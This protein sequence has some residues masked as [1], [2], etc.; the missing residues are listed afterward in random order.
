VS[1]T[2]NGTA[3]AGSEV[4][5]TVSMDVLDRI[6][7]S[8]AIPMQVALKHDDNGG[9]AASKG[10]WDGVRGRVIPNLSTHSTASDFSEPGETYTATAPTPTLAT[11]AAS[12]RGGHAN[13]VGERVRVEGYSVEGTLL[14]YG[15]CVDRPGTQCGVALDRPLGSHDGKVGGVRYF[16]CGV[17]CGVMAPPH[18]VAFVSDG[19]GDN[20][21][22]GVVAAPAQFRDRKATVRVRERSAHSLR[23]SGD[24]TLSAATSTAANSNAGL[25]GLSPLGGRTCTAVWA[26]QARNEDELAFGVGD[27]ITLLETPDGGWWRGR[28]GDAAATTTSSTAPREGW[29]P[30]N[31]VNVDGDGGPAGSAR[32][33]S[34]FSLHTNS[35]INLDGLIGDMSDSSD[36]YEEEDIGSPATT[37]PTAAA[38]TASPTQHQERTAAQPKRKK[39]PVK[40]RK[41][42]APAPAPA[43]ARMVIVQHRYEAQHEDELS[44]ETGDTFRVLKTPGGGWWEGVHPRS[45]QVGWFPST[46]VALV[47]TAKPVVEVPASALIAQAARFGWREHVALHDFSPL[48]DGQVG[49]TKGDSVVLMQDGGEGRSGW[50]EVLANGKHGWVPRPFLSADPVDSVPSSPVSPVSDTIRRTSPKSAA[51]ADDRWSTVDC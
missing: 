10:V 42:S 43:P 32:P 34:F 16:Q 6:A 24:G 9:G 46:H 26:F 14:F 45:G 8:S 30:A 37:S 47:D 1:A 50:C 38:A 29:F 22:S 28:I 5:K 31:H 17:D 23:K 20:V 3:A 33:R 13:R 35:Y 44:L 36:E 12:G 39:P 18:Q 11:T 40:P 41:K 7:S 19:G 51:P 48:S 27:R 2:A 25:H 4:V 15:P 21:A 49:L